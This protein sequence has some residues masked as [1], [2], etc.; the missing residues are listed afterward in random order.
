MFAVKNCQTIDLMFSI[1]EV[2]AWLCEN[3][4]HFDRIELDH[5]LVAMTD[6]P[7][8]VSEVRLVGDGEGGE[9]HDF[10]LIRKAKD[11]FQS[12]VGNAKLERETMFGLEYGGCGDKAID[13]VS[14]K[15]VGYK[16][17]GEKNKAKGINLRWTDGEFHVHEP[18]VFGFIPVLIVRVEVESQVWEPEVV[19]VEVVRDALHSRNSRARHLKRKRPGN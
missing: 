9:F 15:L 4:F 8:D 12:I 19:D 2:E 10:D 3:G 7:Q 1:P 11:L 17:D 18:S 5:G 6:Y 16:I 14:V 13:V